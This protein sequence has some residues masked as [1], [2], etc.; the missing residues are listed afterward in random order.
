MRLARYLSIGLALV[1]SVQAA[2][3]PNRARTA[4][5]APYGF[6]IANWSPRA[7]RE[8]YVSPSSAADWGQE[9]LDGARV[10]AGDDLFLAYGGACQADLRVVFDNGGAEERRGLDVCRHPFIGIR[11]GWTTSDDLAGT[12][13]PGLVLIR[14][15]SGRTVARLHLFADG[16]GQGPDRLGPD[17]LP[18]GFDLAVLL[19]SVGQCDF[20]LHAVFLGEA[21]EARYSGIDLCRSH[22]ITIEPR[23]TAR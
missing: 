22:E 15:R 8:V 20:S 19:P 17:M 18:D 12:I 13:P 2:S 5:P 9:R 6:T 10:R 23:M 21:D 1:C 11:P 3:A 4:P 16:A 7:I 14:N